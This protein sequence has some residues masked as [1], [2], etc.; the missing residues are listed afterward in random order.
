MGLAFHPVDGQDVEVS[1]GCCDAQR[2]QRLEPRRAHGEED[3]VL[4]AAVMQKATL[5]SCHMWRPGAGGE[6]VIH[7]VVL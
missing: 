3:A 6:A 2:F 5:H 7:R 4:A 1:R